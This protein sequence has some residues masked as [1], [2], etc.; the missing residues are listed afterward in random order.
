MPAGS[1]K[2]AYARRWTVIALLIIGCAGVALRG[3]VRQG[4]GLGFDEGIYYSAAGSWVAGFAPYLDFTF[5]HPPGGLILLWPGAFAGEHLV[6]HA[7]GFLIAKSTVALV[8][9]LVITGVGW[10]AYKWVGPIAA[11]LAALLYATFQPGVL[12]E[13]PIRLEPFV[14]LGFVATAGIWLTGH[15][16]A[17]VDRR[18]VVSAAFAGVALVTKLTGGVILIGL[19]ASRPY[20]RP[21]T[22]RILIICIAILAA[23]FLIAPFAL[24]N[25]NTFLEQVVLIQLARPGGDVRGGDIADPISRLLHMLEIG[26]SFRMSQRAPVLAAGALLVLYGS[27]AVWA[28]LRGGPHGRFWAATWAVTLLMFLVSPSYYTQY[29]L[30]LAVPSSVLLAWGISRAMA[31]MRLPTLSITIGLTGIIVVLSAPL[32]PLVL[33]EFDRQPMDTQTAIRRFVPTGECFY[34]DPATLGIA[35]GRLPPADVNGPL[36][37]PF[38]ELMHVALREGGRYPSAEAAL[39]SS[40]AQ[41]RLRQAISACQYVASIYAL[42]SGS[43][44]TPSTQ[45][46]FRR[47]FE[48]VGDP[49]FGVG[50]WQRRAG[51]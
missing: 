34:A 9:L 13:L 40:A 31:A 51:T 5:L 33:R 36:V 18:L 35:A 24:S 26:P 4:V 27:T 29:P 41:E 25:W 15:T 48:R 23:I 44:L 49:I 8:V 37:D 10:L 42:D 47:N 17:R 32:V 1:P 14:N 43:R 6:G 30:L 20:D 38:G 39:S 46:W 50:V 7:A 12:Y 16:V 21:A 22:G 3:F 45:A 11:C 2:A 28:W 19:L